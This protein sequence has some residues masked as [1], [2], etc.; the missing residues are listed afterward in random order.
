MERESHEHSK[1]VKLLEKIPSW[2]QML[3]TL[4]TLIFGLGTMYA[5]LQDVKSQ[6]YQ[7]RDVPSVNSRQD[8]DIN[9]LRQQLIDSKQV[10]VQT[11]MYISKLADAVSSLSSSVARLE[12][13]LDAEDKKRRR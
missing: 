9:N 7:L 5:T 4:G 2:V 1:V 6:V 12:G 13:K 8:A 11:N 10:Q 3:I